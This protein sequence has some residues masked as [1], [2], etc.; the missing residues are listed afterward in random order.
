MC[1]PFDDLL[2]IGRAGRQARHDEAAPPPRLQTD[3]DLRPVTSDIRVGPGDECDPVGD[4]RLCSRT[5][6]GEHPMGDIL[7]DD[8]G[9]E[10]LGSARDD[11]T[12]LGPLEAE[13]RVGLMDLPRP[14]ETPELLGQQRAVGDLGDADE[15]D[16]MREDDDGKL[17]PGRRMADH[18]GG[19]LI[20]IRGIVDE[21]DDDTRGTS[22]LELIEE[23]RHCGRGAAEGLRGRKD[24]FAAFEELLDVFGIGDVHPP[25][26]AIEVGLPGHDLGRTAADLLEIEH[27]GDGEARCGLRP[28]N[29]H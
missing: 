10:Q 26:R 6:L 3:R 27:P 20:R 17:A 5:G 25:D 7:E 12:D 2:D 16:P 18:L 24:E 13:L 14:F 29:V 1:R 15:L 19:L 8:R 28:L 23:D 4:E 9:S 21:F 11:R 22:R